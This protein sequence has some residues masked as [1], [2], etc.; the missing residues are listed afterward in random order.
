MN[1]WPTGVGTRSALRCTVAPSALS[2]SLGLVSRAVSPRSTLPVL[3]N[4]LLETESEG[5]RI[6]ATNLDLT[7]SALVPAT[8]HEEGRVTVPARLLA[9]YVASLDETACTLEVEERTQMLRIT[10]GVQKANLH[11]IDAVEFPPL[12][13]R[14]TSPAFEVDAASLQ[15]AITQTAVAASG[16]E[17]TPVLT[18]VLLH[19]EGS[20]L[21][22]VATDRHRL[23]VKN[24]EAQVLT[25]GVV[26]GTV[27]VPA[28]HLGELARAIN[29]S[30]PRVGVAFSDARNQVFF[31]LRDMEISSR[32]IEGNYPNY[33][34][35]IPAHSTTTVVLPTALLLHSARTAAVL[36]RDASNP[37]RLRA[38]QG[39]SSCWPRRPR[40]ATT[41]PRSPP[42]WTV[43]RCRSPSTRATSST[44]CR[45]S[46][47]T[48][49]SCPSTDPCSP[50]WCA[51]RAATTTSASSCRCAS[52]DAQLIAVKR[53]LLTSSTPRRELRARTM[54]GISSCSC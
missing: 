15:Q 17:Q 48:T 41:M 47:A 32:L 16:D 39:S 18:G 5:L 19:V 40:W 36:A 33:T 20:K 29:P 27:I 52:P 1:N 9:E 4:V 3:S 26:S 46:T 30:R 31:T 14:E 38:G 12:P 25:E 21:T 35:V 10:A 24:L 23:A 42:R 53:S 11:G 54:A 7:I 2:S 6:T 34:Q 49:W 8:V 37:V 43:R 45:R 22:L 51:L 28:R 13:A 50:R 44:P